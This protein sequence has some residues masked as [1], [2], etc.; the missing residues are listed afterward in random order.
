MDDRYSEFVI[1]VG[2]LC[3]AAEL[4]RFQLEVVTDDGQVVVGQ[5]GAPRT[6]AGDAELDHTGLQRTVRVDGALVNLDEIVRCTIHRPEVVGS[7]P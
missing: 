6:A 3:A 2:Q 5:V 1:A 7:L 4:A